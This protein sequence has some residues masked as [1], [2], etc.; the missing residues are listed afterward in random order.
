MFTVQCVQPTEG[1]SLESVENEV[2][3]IVCYYNNNVYVLSTG[4]A[5]ACSNVHCAQ[6]KTE[7]GRFGELILSLF[8]L[9]IVTKFV[10][11]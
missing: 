9:Y 4:A 3:Y 1:K 6:P 2:H 10:G 11:T 7:D 5:D 8:E